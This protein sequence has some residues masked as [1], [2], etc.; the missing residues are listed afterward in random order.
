MANYL[1]QNDVYNYGSDLIDFTQRAAAQAV[2][3]HLQ[4]LDQQNAELRRQVAEQARKAMHERVE[5]AIP[6][7][8]EIDQD[9]RWHS[10]LLQLDPLA[11]R[12]RQTL[13]DEAISTGDAHRV[14]AFFRGF[15]AEHGG[16]EGRSNAGGTRRARSASGQQVYTREQIKQFYELHRRGKLQGDEWNRIERDIIAASAEGRVANAVEP[17]GR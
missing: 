13:L 16:G 5:A 2:A 17:R 3:P 11:G 4:A 8:H 1:T 7:W 12:I 6:N 9:P 14:L 10:W 15:A